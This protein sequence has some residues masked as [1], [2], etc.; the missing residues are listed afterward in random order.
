MIASVLTVLAA[1]VF[2]LFAPMRENVS[3]VSLEPLAH[4]AR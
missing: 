4:A 2:V 3:A 1:R